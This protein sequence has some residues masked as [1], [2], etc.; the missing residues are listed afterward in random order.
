MTAFITPLKVVLLP[1]TELEVP[2]PAS[3]VETRRDLDSWAAMSMTYLW[4]YEALEVESGDPFMDVEV[5]NGFV[6]TESMFKAKGLLLSVAGLLPA[7]CTS[8]SG[9]QDWWRF[10]TQC[11]RGTGIYW[12]ECYA[13]TPPAWLQHLLAEGG[14][15]AVAASGS[16]CPRTSNEDA[17][18]LVKESVD[19]EVSVDG[20]W[21]ELQ[22]ARQHFLEKVLSGA[23]NIERRGRAL[24]GV[25]ADAVT[26]S[27]VARFMQKLGMTMSASFESKLYGERDGHL[28][29]VLGRSAWCSL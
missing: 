27:V 25:R 17:A 1:L 19:Q 28:L 6:V 26:G 15:S 23:W 22:Q 4:K 12:G 14:Q 8:G 11:S 24:F 16:A 13:E 18:V 10:P 9:R 2:Q 20:V 5:A 29:G 3:T 7:T 21:E